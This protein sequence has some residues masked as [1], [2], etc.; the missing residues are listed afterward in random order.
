MELIQVSLY[1]QYS[2]N[3]NLDKMNL[4]VYSIFSSVFC[5]LLFDNYLN[6]PGIRPFD[7]IGW[8][9]LF[10]SS[11]F[12]VDKNKFIS[13]FSNPLALMYVFLVAPG[14][15]VGIFVLSASVIPFVIG[16]VEFL[17]LS[18]SI[19]F[20][21]N[22]KNIVKF[23][24]LFI[25]VSLLIQYII[26]QI[27]GDAYSFIVWGTEVEL[28]ANFRDLFF[29]VSGIYIEPSSHAIAVIILLGIYT[30]MIKRRDYCCYISV[31]SILASMSLSG[32]L[33]M[34]IYL[35]LPIGLKIN[36]RS[37]ALKI[38]ALLLLTAVA[39]PLTVNN[40]AFSLAIFDRIDR[41]QSGDD[42]SADDRLGKLV[43][44]SC[45]NFIEE[46]SILFPLIGSGVSSAAHAVECGS[47]TLAWS[48]VSLGLIP[49][50]LIILSIILVLFRTPLLLFSWLFLLVFSPLQSYGLFWFFVAA[51]KV[52]V[53]SYS[54][55]SSEM[56]IA[57]SVRA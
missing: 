37:I 18:S 27:T 49:T 45:H 40:E 4:K 48:V 19:L 32:V 20:A 42:G 30:T 22:L 28:R 16:F 52:I 53:N 14:V 5:F 3:L 55:K 7:F 46:N 17:I 1:F 44:N 13:F 12:I 33:A 34:L 24:L 38:S 41:V 11:I 47:N 21:A 35:I 50:I 10:F 8:I 9:V 43:S 56:L 54:R 15:L 31:L 57:T 26:Y 2:K 23:S 29:R 39:V 36:A 25:S 6:P 51:S